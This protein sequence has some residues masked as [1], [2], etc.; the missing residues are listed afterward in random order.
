MGWCSCEIEDCST[1]EQLRQSRDLLAWVQAGLPCAKM[2]KN[3]SSADEAEPVISTTAIQVS[4]LVDEK[5]CIF[6]PENAS[7]NRRGKD[8]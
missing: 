8:D 7:Q 3:L 4:Q 2:K 1:E 6:I 5:L